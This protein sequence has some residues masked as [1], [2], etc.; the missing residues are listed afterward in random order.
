MTDPYIEALLEA[1]QQIESLKEVLVAAE[2]W[3]SDEIG[4]SYKPRGK[5]I[6][7]E[8]RSV[9]DSTARGEGDAAHQIVTLTAERDEARAT[10]REYHE[11]RIY[12]EGQA[13]IV[14]RKQA[15]ADV[16]EAIA[17]LASASG[18]T[19]IAPCDD[20][21]FGCE[22]YE[23]LAPASPDP[24]DAEIGRL[25]EAL[26]DIAKQTMSDE[27]DEDQL[28]HAD[29]QFGYDACVARARREQ[30]VLASPQHEEEK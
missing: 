28:D 30:N 19:K 17:A 21:E 18:E 7:A 16:A 12:W 8:V 4:D 14:A 22:K 15:L 20:A 26:K 24:R 23:G 27:M 1:Q 6:L 10:L 5:R 11:T 3:M 25:L 13:T 2:S 29:W 9:L